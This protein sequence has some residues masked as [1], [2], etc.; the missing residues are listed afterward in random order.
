MQ[1]T[2]SKQQLHHLA[3]LTWLAL[4][5]QEE[6]RYLKEFPHI[7]KM[8]SKLDEIDVDRIQVAH[9][10][11]WSKVYMEADELPTWVEAFENVD[12]LLNQVPHPLDKRR[13]KLTISTNA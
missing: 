3:K 2:L 7:F 6:E 1:Q 9:N 5:A 10:M 4:T 11:Q 8:L 12:G 13:I